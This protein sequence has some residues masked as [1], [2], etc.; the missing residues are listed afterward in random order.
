MVSRW[1]RP[2]TLF[3][4]LAF[5]AVWTGP[6]ALAQ[7]VQWRYDYDA[8]RREA[9]E[10]QRPILL[11]FG[12][13]N[14]FWCKQLD[15][16]TFHDPKI[17]HQLNEQFI[18]VKVQAEN[19]PQLTEALRIQSF[20]T[21]VFATADGRILAIKEGFMD[22]D[23]F[24]QEMQKVLG[25]TAPVVRA[26]APASSPVSASEASKNEISLRLSAPPA[27]PISQ[28]RGLEARDLLASAQ[29]DQCHGRLLC[30][31]ERCARLISSTPDLPEAEE[32]RRLTIRIKNDP[33]LAKQLSQQLA[34]QLT[35]L[36][37]IQAD[38]ALRANDTTRAA[39]CLERVAQVC[40]GTPGAQ[41]AQERLDRLRS[42]VAGQVNA[43]KTVR[44]QSP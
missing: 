25:E 36:L 13:T 44:G 24:G 17:A 38:S 16:V 23:P 6:A 31:L 5:L 35:D 7:E 4:S 8:A 33:A 9:R 39:A 19:V 14:C 28:D 20:P 43:P 22:V 37:F 3:L 10:T 12:T 34:D 41:L 40:P 27:A 1:S 29:D 21:L 32:A 26:P 30:C 2:R 42:T 18:P 15:K 11:D